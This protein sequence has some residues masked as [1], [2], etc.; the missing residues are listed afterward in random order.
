GAVEART[1][2]V[3]GAL[4]AERDFVTPASRVDLRRDV[5]P[6]GAEAHD[7][8]IARAARR[9]EELQIVNRLEEIG[10]A[11]TVLPDD[12]P[13]R[14]RP[15]EL[16]MREVSKIANGKT[17]ESSGSPPPP[18]GHAPVNFAARFSRN[19]RVPSRLSSVAPSSPNDDASS[20]SA[21]SSE[22]S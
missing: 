20:M 2:P 17:R 8:G 9:P 3:S 12:H 5:E 21:A 18:R 16:D 13:T 4:E 6:L 11:L 14:G 10:L 15:G 22:E 7:V 1:L 19:A